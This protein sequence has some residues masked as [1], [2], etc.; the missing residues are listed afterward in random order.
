M[1]ISNENLITLSNKLITNYKL[2]SIAGIADSMQLAILMADGRLERDYPNV[3]ISGLVGTTLKER[4]FVQGRELY[5]IY[6]LFLTNPQTWNQYSQSNSVTDVK[7]SAGS[8]VSFSNK[9]RIS[10][11]DFATQIH[12]IFIELGV[13][14]PESKIVFKT[15]AN[16]LI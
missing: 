10:L 16:K 1:P 2:S 6:L 3:Y 15:Q 14:D 11:I 9:N 8:A 4:L 13:V 5:S 7:N 12:K